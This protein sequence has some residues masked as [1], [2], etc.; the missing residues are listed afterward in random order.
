MKLCF[1]TVGAT[2]SFEKLIEQVLSPQ[3]LE[4][5]AERRY[6]HLLIQ[7]GK[8]GSEAFSSF[9]NGKQS[10]HGLTIGGFESKPS[11]DEELLMTTKRGDQEKGLI[12]SHAGT[13]SILAA[14]RIGT[15]LIVV[16]NPDLADNHQEELAQ[17]LQ[18]QKYV[19]SSSVQE[20]RT[21]V[22]A[23]AELQKT[24]IFDSHP[25]IQDEHAGFMSDDLGFLD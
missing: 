8:G 12:I 2:A 22:V 16:P 7:Y 17:I 4:T 14:M 11:L 1:V 18:E 6:T 19:V 3:F 25:E 5:L 15:P 20:I 24:Q 21:L 9:A 13:G 10:A 23:R